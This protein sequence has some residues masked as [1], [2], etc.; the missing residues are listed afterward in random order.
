MSKN[1]ITGDNIQTRVASE[2]YLSNYDAIFRKKIILP[3]STDN[4]IMLESE[5]K[6]KQD[7][8]EI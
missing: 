5:T 2:D 8:Q 1:D 3:I 7:V 4:G 6:E